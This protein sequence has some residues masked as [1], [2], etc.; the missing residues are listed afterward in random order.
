MNQ[1]N[2]STT[3]ETPAQDVKTIAAIDI[4]SNSVRLEVAEVLPDGH[5]EVLEQLQQ[6]V[7]LGQDTFR[8]GRIGRAST[9]AT[10]GILRDFRRVLDLYKVQRLRAVATSAVREASNSDAFLD[11]MLMT[12]DLDVEV[13][14][15]SEESRLTVSAVRQKLGGVMGINRG[16]TLIA[17]VGGGSSLLTFLQDGDIAA[18][19][20]LRLGAVRLQEQLVSPGE[21]LEQ[22]MDILRHHIR[23]TLSVV[24][25]S[26][27]VKKCQSFVAVGGDA[28]FAARQVGQEVA[29]TEL[30]RVSRKDLDA[31][32]EQVLYHTPE[33]ISRDYGVPYALA[34]TIN[35]ALRVYQEL[36]HAT[37]AKEMLVS[38]VSMRDGLLL[39]LARS[40]TGDEDESLSE[41]I[42][43]SALAV[44]DKYLVDHDHAEQVA[45]ISVRLFD[46]L[47]DEH[48]LD[49][50][51]R[52]VL[53]VA[54]LMHEVGGYVSSR[55]H[56]KHS[57]YLISN[58]EVFGLTREEL[59][60]VAHVARYHRRAMPRSSHT[61]Y[62]ALPRR[63]RMVVSKLAAILRVADALDRGHGQQIGD[64]TCQRKDNDFVIYVHGVGDLTLERRAISQKGDLFEDIYGMTVRVEEAPLA[65]PARRRAAPVE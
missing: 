14:D 56:H 12:V 1:A 65:D 53:R 41:G 13:I 55:A 16:H 37:K 21:P 50:R 4:G 24:Q 31:L 58:S 18:S 36:L 11:R 33:E 5:I 39:D 2:A 30:R 61:E 51:Q 44:A 22:S 20:S 8:R 60:V 26:L 54:G 28:R 63:L 59:Q 32:V 38:E 25:S 19:Q 27:P 6:A 43:Q 10:V 7:R 57:Y 49:A 62:M 48:G 9:Q 3:P 46:E 35:P 52:L 64:F 47:Q 34:E 42:V 45:D 40:V 29:G 23:N 17:D 15:T